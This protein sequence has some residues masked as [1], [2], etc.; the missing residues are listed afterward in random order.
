MVKV[1]VVE[2]VAKAERLALMSRDEYFAR[3]SEAAGRC[4]PYTRTVQDSPILGRGLLSA[5]PL[6]L[7]LPFVCNYR[8]IPAGGGS[9]W[10]RHLGGALPR[11]TLR[12]LRHAS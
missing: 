9:G 1:V 3:M 8:N 10:G 11:P 6:P 12:V 5:M 2:W 7:L 4:V